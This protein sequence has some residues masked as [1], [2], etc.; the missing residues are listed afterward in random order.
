M[1]LK[2]VMTT[3]HLLKVALRVYDKFCVANVHTLANM[4]PKIR[5]FFAQSL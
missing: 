5:S 4:G 3:P 1:A 2:V